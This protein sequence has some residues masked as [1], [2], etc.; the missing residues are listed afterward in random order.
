MSIT[1]T[2]KTACIPPWGKCKRAQLSRLSVVATAGSEDP[3]RICSSSQHIQS[4]FGPTGE[5]NN[6]LEKGLLSRMT[7]YDLESTLIVQG[8]IKDPRRR[9]EH[10]GFPSDSGFAEH[11]VSTL[12]THSN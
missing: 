11:P 1:I 3:D 7:K 5:G 12:I 10:T 6:L 2:K 9:R 8:S 4:W